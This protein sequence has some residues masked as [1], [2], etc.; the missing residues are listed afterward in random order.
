M[1]R[2]GRAVIPAVCPSQAGF[3][4]SLAFQWSWRLSIQSSECI[5]SDEIMADACLYSRAQAARAMQ[6]HDHESYLSSSLI[7]FDLRTS[8]V[9]L[10]LAR[11]VPKDGNVPTFFHR[12]QR[13]SSRS[14]S[15][16]PNTFQKGFATCAMPPMTQLE[17]ANQKHEGAH[18]SFGLAW[19]AET[20][21]ARI[22]TERVMGNE[23]NSHFC[24]GSSSKSGILPVSC[25]ASTRVHLH[26]ILDFVTK[27][28]DAACQF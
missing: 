22:G 12:V 13:Y 17:S 8:P 26:F 18:A 24:E 6:W 19:S 15:R 9:L 11:V 1:P 5:L 21:H 28:E 2:R 14:L 20:A 16:Q 4:W 7:P 27:L 3:T 25:G 23:R 10:S